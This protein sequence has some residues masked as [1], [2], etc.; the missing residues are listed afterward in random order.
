MLVL[1][2]FQAG[3]GFSGT[4]KSS[5]AVRRSTFLSKGIPVFHDLGNCLR[6]LGHVSRYH[7]QRNAGGI[8]KH[9]RLPE[10]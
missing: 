10:A 6:A 1:S 9:S 8:L 7:A 5:S 2:K 4:S 3:H